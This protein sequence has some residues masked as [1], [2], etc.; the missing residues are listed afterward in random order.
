[1]Y[2]HL[3]IDCPRLERIYLEDSIH[4]MFTNV[5]SCNLENLTALRTVVFGTNT[6]PNASVLRIAQCLYIRSLTIGD[7]CFNGI[8]PGNLILSCTIH[9]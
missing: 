9:E 5:F 8:Q 4:G 2:I 3:Q 7:G 1:M 6:F